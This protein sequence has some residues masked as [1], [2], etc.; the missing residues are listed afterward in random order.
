MG[1]QHLDTILICEHKE[2]GDSLAD[3]VKVGESGSTE[4]QE[5]EVE[6]ASLGGRQAQGV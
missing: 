1:H 2:R 5:K 4:E 3:G 6:G